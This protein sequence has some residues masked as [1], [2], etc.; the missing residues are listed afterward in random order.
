MTAWISHWYCEVIFGY[1][2]GDVLINKDKIVLD[3]VDEDV[4]FDHKISKAMVVV[5]VPG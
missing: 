5:L 4:L 3:E 1:T 2:I